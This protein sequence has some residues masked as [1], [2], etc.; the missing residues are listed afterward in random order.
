[1]D[2][3]PTSNIDNVVIFDSAGNAKDSGKKLNE[4]ATVVVT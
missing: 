3:A 1:M 4:V 2:K